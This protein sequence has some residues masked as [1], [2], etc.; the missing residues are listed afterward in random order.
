MAPSF[1]AHACWFLPAFAAHVAEE[2][3]GFTAWAQRNAPA[4]YSQGDSLRNNA[5]GLVG[6]AATTAAV[7][8]GDSRPVQLAYYTLVVIQ[9][10]VFNAVFH[11]GFTLAFREY[12]PGLITSLPNTGLWRGLTRAAL[13]ESRVAQRDL[14]ACIHVAGA[15]HAAV[16]ARQVFFLGVPEA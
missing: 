1:R 5:L 2:A 12:S 8:R 7:V 10:A 15:V 9:Q 11:A 3:A 14:S 13:A 6:T 16:V 4:R